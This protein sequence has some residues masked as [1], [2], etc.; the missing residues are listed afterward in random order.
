MRASAV[1]HP[2]VALIKYW[3]KRA[4]AG[5]L[6]ATG[7]LSVTLGGMQ[8]QTTVQFSAGLAADE[9]SLNGVVDAGA[10]ARVTTCLDML[11]ADAG[12]QLRARVESWNDF[13]TGAGLAS[14]ASGFAALALAGA[15]ALGLEPE[16]SRLQEVARVGSGSAPRSLFGG[17]VQLR[18]QG[19]GTVCEPL[20]GPAEWPVSV[21]VAITR[22]EAKETGS[23]PG[24]RLSE[25][26]SP[27]Y[28]VWVETHEADIQRALQCIAERDFTGLAEVSEHSCLKMHAVMMT[29]RPPL[30]YWSPATLACILAIQ[31]LR[32]EGVPVFFTVD[33]GPQIKA[34]CLSEASGRV[35]QVLSAIPGVL[36][37]VSSPLGEAARVTQRDA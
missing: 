18:N 8:T 33:A 20:L 4:A 16:P 24:M 9:V 6:P 34:V 29:S 2:N 19:E 7:S 26:T 23:R 36:R 12:T 31:A 11:R 25:A 14:S 15:A 22:L 1:A 27:C 13:P 10:S 37:T 17:F 35:E 32:A 30:M 5:N 3:G 28:P 21:V